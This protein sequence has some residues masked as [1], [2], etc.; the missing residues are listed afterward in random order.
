MYQLSNTFGNKFVLIRVQ[1]CVSNINQSEASLM[2][3]TFVTN[4]NKLWQTNKTINQLTNQQAR[5]LTINQ[6]GTNCVNHVVI[7]PATN[8][9]TNQKLQQKF[10][11]GP[12][13]EEKFGIEIKIR[14]RYKY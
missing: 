14:N 8:R 12:K 10:E 3:R 13:F 5:N 6:V 9:M 11:I 4:Y 2:I 7:L 1:Y